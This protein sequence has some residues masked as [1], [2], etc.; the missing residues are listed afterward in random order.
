LLQQLKLSFFIA[1]NVTEEEVLYNYNNK[2]VIFTELSGTSLDRCIQSIVITFLG[3]SVETLFRDCPEFF[4]KYCQT[5]EKQRVVKK[6][7]EGSF[8]SKPEI[9]KMKLYL[10]S[11]VSLD[12]DSTGLHFLNGRLDLLSLEFSQRE[13]RH[14]ITKVL[15]YNYVIPQDLNAEALKM[16]ASLKQYFVE[17]EALVYFLSMIGKSL[18]GGNVKDCVLFYFYGEGSCGKTSF[19][20]LLKNAF[21]SLIYHMASSSLDSKAEA[22]NTF[23]GIL[24]YHRF[25]FWNE[26]TP[27]KKMSSAVK[28]LCDGVVPTRQLRIRDIRRRRSMRNF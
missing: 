5:K 13:P 27:A 17:D 10:D 2:F 9:W 25:M 11:S 19:L 26:P 16:L 23:N 28:T 7:S 24:L 22:N 12:N 21:D 4:N 8:F 14:F 6:L 18:R 1:K 3:R 15:N 20:N